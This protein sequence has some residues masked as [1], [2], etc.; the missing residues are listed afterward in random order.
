MLLD[1]LEE[2]LNLPTRLVDVGDGQR[3]EREV[4][5]QKLQPLVRPG[6]EVTDP[7][8][9]VGIGLGR[10]DGSQYDG[11]IRAQARGFVDGMRVAPLEQDVLLG[12]HDEERR[13]ESEHEEAFE[14]DVG[15]IHDV[16]RAG[17]RADLV[18]DV[19]VVHFASSNADER[20]NIAVQ[21][22]QRVHLHGG[23][24]LAESRPRKQRQAEVDCCRVESVQSLV[25]V[26]TDRVVGI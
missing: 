24:L 5:G 17:L 2:Q 7:P 25:Q 8:Q 21:I 13:A 19:D 15:P 12:S 23:F 18:E 6:V 3:R 26:H 4:V 1:P 14:I 20:G 16:E 10:F 9:R 11:L 22:Q